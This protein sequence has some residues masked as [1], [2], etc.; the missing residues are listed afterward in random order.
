MNTE[1]SIAYFKKL[2]W[3]LS[4]DADYESKN[5]QYKK[6]WSLN[7]DSRT[8]KPYRFYGVNLNEV[9]ELWDMLVKNQHVKKVENLIV[10]QLAFSDNPKFNQEIRAWA[11]EKIERPFSFFLEKEISSLMHQ[12]PTLPSTWKAQ[13]AA[14]L[15]PVPL[16]V[17]DLERSDL[18]NLI[19]ERDRALLSE[20]VDFSLTQ[21][22]KPKVRL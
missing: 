8:L 13:I 3:T 10:I 1:Q 11:A 16:S 5:G 15:L 18:L 22:S 19:I 4:K 6:I 17:P 21:T 7:S 9:W 20:K 2:G 12:A 14:G